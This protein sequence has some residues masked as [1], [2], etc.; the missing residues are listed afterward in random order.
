MSKPRE[1]DVVM[2]DEA[3]G[4]RGKASLSPYQSERA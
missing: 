2:S 1:E 4:E 3:E